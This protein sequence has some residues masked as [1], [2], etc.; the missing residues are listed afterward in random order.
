MGSRGSTCCRSDRD[1]NPTGEFRPRARVRRVCRGVE[2]VISCDRGVPQR[3]R[4]SLFYRGTY[5]VHNKKKSWFLHAVFL[6]FNVLIIECKIQLSRTF[7]CTHGKKRETN[8]RARCSRRDLRVNP[9]GIFHFAGDVD[10]LVVPREGDDGCAV[11]LQ[12]ALRLEA[13]PAVLS[14]TWRRRP[15]DSRC[16]HGPRG[17][18]WLGP[19]Q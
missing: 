11:V 9:T 5:C 12:A 1:S 3:R 18:A 7:A 15:R 13:R 4:L 19:Q 16:Q 17:E 14:E 8:G 10:R 2:G 6:S